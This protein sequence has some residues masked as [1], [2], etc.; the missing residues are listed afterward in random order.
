MRESRA[1]ASRPIAG[2]VGK[3]FAGTGPS[4]S[5]RAAVWRRRIDYRFGIFF[6]ASCVAFAQKFFGLSQVA[7]RDGVLPR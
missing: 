5:E 4:K 3:P 6:F 7:A 2:G 1:P